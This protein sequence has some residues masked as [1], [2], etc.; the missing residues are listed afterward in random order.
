[1]TAILSNG[2]LVVLRRILG[3]N[4]LNVIDYELS[5]E[6][7]R[8]PRILS[9]DQLA[10]LTAAASKPKELDNIALLI[11]NWL[12]QHHLASAKALQDWLKK[13]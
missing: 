11:H 8:T 9:D 5:I 7:T 12:A 1:M 2:Q 6:T 13:R 10:Q 4:S 3:T